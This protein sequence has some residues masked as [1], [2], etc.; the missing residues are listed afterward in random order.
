MIAALLNRIKDEVWRSFAFRVYNTFKSVIAPIV[1][2]LVLMELENNPGDLS[3]L[4][5]KSF[6]YKVL[7]AVVIAIVGGAIAGIDK[8]NRMTK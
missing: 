1:L 3:C 7:Y 4:L 5:D 8:V 2:S 6:W